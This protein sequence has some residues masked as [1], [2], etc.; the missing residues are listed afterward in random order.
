MSHLPQYAAGGDHHV[1]LAKSVRDGRSYPD[2]G[3]MDRSHRVDEIARLLSGEQISEAA[4]CNA[5][6]LLSAAG[7]GG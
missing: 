3:P 5:E 4:R 2:V 7:Q 6:E 1:L